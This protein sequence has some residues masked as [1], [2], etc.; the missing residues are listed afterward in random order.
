[1]PWKL[2]Y[3]GICGRHVKCGNAI[4]ST[5]TICG[6]K[7]CSMS[8]RLHTQIN[9][10]S[11][12]KISLMTN[13]IKYLFTEFY[14]NKKNQHRNVDDKM[15]KCKTLNH[16]LVSSWISAIAVVGVSIVVIIRADNNWP[17]YGY[18]FSI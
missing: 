3:H 9:S 15:K 2:V 17:N 6:Q 16:E 5:V 4:N 13:V 7:G 12:F 11:S 18:F 1:M 10:I 8:G 14:S